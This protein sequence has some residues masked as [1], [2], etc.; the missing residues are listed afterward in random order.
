MSVYHIKLIQAPNDD[1]F[2]TDAESIYVWI[3]D[4][5]CAKMKQRIWC[6]LV[7]SYLIIR[8]ALIARDNLQN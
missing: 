8:L 3:L 6:I 1:F 2:S 4:I 5:A 7:I